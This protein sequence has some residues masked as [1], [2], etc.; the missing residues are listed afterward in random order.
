VRKGDLVA[1]RRGMSQDCF[2]QVALVLQELNEV[3][4]TLVLWQNSKHWVYF[5]DL[6]IISRKKT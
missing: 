6:V 5:E 2:P 1:F 4:K 3:G